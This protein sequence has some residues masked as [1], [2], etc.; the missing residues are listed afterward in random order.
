LDKGYS[1][2]LKLNSAIVKNKYWVLPV[3]DVGHENYEPVGRGLPSSPSCG[4]HRGIVVCKNIEGHKGV[5][6]GGRDCTGK[7]VVRHKHMWCHKSSC[8]VCFIR[9][10][11]V[12]GA[13]N[14]TGRVDEGVRRDFG[15]VEH[16]MVSVA[17]ADRGLP[18]E[19]LRK[20]ARSALKARGIFGGCMIF[21]GYRMDRNRGVLVWSPHYHCL[22]F[23]LDGYSRCRNCPRKSNCDPNCD[24]FDSRA[25]KLFN[26][27]GY[28]VK[29]FAERETVFGTAFYQLNHA[30]IR[31]GV[32]RFHAVT[33]FGACG[34]R[35]YSA[36]KVL[37]VDVCPACEE[38]MV[39]SVYVGKRPF[40]KSV[41]HPDY[42]SVSLRD[43]F[44]E[45]GEPN[46]VDYVPSSA[47]CRVTRGDY[48]HFPV[49]K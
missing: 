45:D 48:F 7:V 14:I 27:D 33:W 40:V 49:E 6:V 44:G 8:P 22:G 28:Y 39:R 34:N 38:E 2:R 25:W 12:R 24:G 36:P 5:S 30:T 11:S 43:E 26:E 42:E 3:D 37:S 21:H 16:V 19:V 9:G 23:V 15:V 46:F 1:R 10:W 18:E 17:V 41:A 20:K 13:R 35:K 4:Q 47:G 31:L 29:V 32:R